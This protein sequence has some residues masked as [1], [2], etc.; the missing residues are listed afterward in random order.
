MNNHK[1]E[2]LIATIFIGLCCTVAMG[3][4]SVS[5]YQL[6]IKDSSLW[7]NNLYRNL[8]IIIMITFTLSSIGDLTHT[9][10]RYTAHTDISFDVSRI[11]S[12][13]VDALYFGGNIMFYTLI[14]LRI[15]IPFQLN[16]CVFIGLSIVIFITGI[17]SIVYCVSVW[18][19]YYGH[20]EYWRIILVVLSGN[21]FILN[22]F[23]LILFAR[24]MRNTAINIDSTFSE[25]AKK[26]KNLITNA[27]S[28]HSVL[29]G[30]AIFVNQG[31][32]AS[33]LYRAFSGDYNFVVDKCLPY[34]IRALETVANVLV[35]W[36]VLNINYNKYICLC[37]CCHLC[38]GKFC[39][40]YSDESLLHN[41]YYEL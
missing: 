38:V 10:I 18:F 33:H 26:N 20:D 31:W 3:I 2:L 30:I 27:I 15:S 4:I 12:N 37:R 1:T 41:P 14:L 11:N 9:I 6:C 29:F 35:L 24:K 17:V 16:K 34:S 7:I 21:D 22:L 40:R 25:L 28:K 13:V 32:F 5:I 8:T 19:I 36:L 39:F 23:I